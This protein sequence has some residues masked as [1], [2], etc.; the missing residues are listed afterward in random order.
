MRYHPDKQQQQQQGGDDGGGVDLPSLFIRINIAAEVL[1]DETKRAQYDELLADGVLDHSDNEYRMLKRRQDERRYGRFQAYAMRTARGDV[2]WAELAVMAASLL[3]FVGP[4]LRWAWVERRRR[5]RAKT[6]E[7]EAT[8]RSKK[9]VERRVEEGRRREEERERRR[10]QPQAREAAGSDDDEEEAALDGESEERRREKEARRARAKKVRTAFRGALR[11]CT[12]DAEEE[13]KEPE[14]GETAASG[15]QLLDSEDVELLLRELSVEELER[16]L[17]AVEQ[18]TAADDE[19][20]DAEE[21]QRK[22]H[23]IVRAEVRSH[24]AA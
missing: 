11:S 21:S 12:R 14:G 17:T 20:G 24:S 2:D 6:R 23:R 16:L 19:T 9:E 7:K 10:A 15:E 22:V 8:K 5:E 3:C 4:A 13:R 18:V 1:G